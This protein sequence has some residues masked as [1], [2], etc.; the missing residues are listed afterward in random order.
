M[1]ISDGFIGILHG[2][3]PSGQTMPLGSNKHVTSMKSRNIFLR[4]KVASA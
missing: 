2:N 4:V 3:N 1:V